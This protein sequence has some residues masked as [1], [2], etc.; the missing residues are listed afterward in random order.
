MTDFHG[1]DHVTVAANNKLL[2]F[3]SCCSCEFSYLFC[4]MGSGWGHLLNSVQQAAELGGSGR[5]HSKASHGFSGCLPTRSF[6]TVVSWPFFVAAG[7]SPF[8]PSQKLPQHPPH[9]KKPPTSQKVIRIAL[10][11]GGETPFLM[12]GRAVGLQ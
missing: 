9:H 1:L 6:L 12:V 4:P 11:P 7:L 8:S 5:L 10:T 3:Q 2:D